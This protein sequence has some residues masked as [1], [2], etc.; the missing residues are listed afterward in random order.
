M[1]QEIPDPVIFKDTDLIFIHYTKAKYTYSRFEDVL[2]GMPAYLVSEISEVEILLSE[3]NCTK[4]VIKII[5]DDP[6]TLEPKSALVFETFGN[7]L[8]VQFGNITA[9]EALLKEECPR[10][11]SVKTF[12]DDLK[13]C[14]LMRL[15]YDMSVTK[16][17]SEGLILNCIKTLL[18]TKLKPIN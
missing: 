5:G 9:I 14:E 11:I 12:A 3:N 7:K 15:V 1:Y 10:N 17:A 16:G 8:L 2:Q 18:E 13:F 6:S 4:T